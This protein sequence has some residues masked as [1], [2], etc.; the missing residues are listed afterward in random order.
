MDNNSS[1][2]SKELFHVAGDAPDPSGTG[3]RGV[4]PGYDLTKSALGHPFLLWR[5]PDGG[6]MMLEADVYAMPGSPM[7]IIILCPLCA[8]NGRTSGLRID[9]AKKAMSYDEKASISCFPGWTKEQTKGAF[10]NG[11]GGVLSVEPF[12][13]TWEESPD[14]KRD[15]GLSKCNWRVAIDNNFV[16]SV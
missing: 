3:L 5:R 6:E 11:T 1:P 7:Y 10:P 9:Q 15:F 2:T 13:C 16:R 12:A 8:M 14:L 4:S